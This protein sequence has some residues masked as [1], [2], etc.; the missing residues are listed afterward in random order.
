MRKLFRPRVLV[1]L[2]AAV[3]AIGGVAAAGALLREDP[4]PR[5]EAAP[6]PA[7]SSTTTTTTTTTAPPTT[8]TTLPPDTIIQPA[9]VDLPPVPWEGW[10]PGARAPE[11]QAYEQRLADLR[12][13]PGP[14]DGVF[15]Q[16]TVYAMQGVQKIA[17]FPTS[18]R[19]GPGE[20]PYLETFQ[21]PAPLQVGGEPNR[22]EVDITKQVVTLYE[23]YQPRLITTMSSG[24]GEHY[25]YNSPRDNPT[26]RIC[27][28]AYTPSGR[29]TYYY[30]YDGWHK[31][32]LGQ[33][34]NPYYF[35][36][37]IAVHGY[38]DVPV[39]PA[40]HGC[41]RI[42]MH[43]AEYWNTLVNN[44]DPV[45]V[46]GGQEAVIT[47]REPL[48]GSA[49]PP[50]ADP[51]PIPPP[52]EPAPPPPPEPAPPPPEPVLPTTPSLPTP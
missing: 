38:E 49:S 26:E 51:D 44:D 3:V 5:V 31:S 45:Y 12:F 50:P 11:I 16:S 25:C 7:P 41:V 30:F 20:E 21:F 28:Y 47:S 6:A 27:E 43:I 17:G 23:H 34:Y 36:K 37:G 42:P 24:S 46:F 35:N 15:D 48:G 18:G 22:T 1:S 39:Y 32:P 9:P 4:A 52:G 40:S 13:D 2:L 29:Y 10:G 14:I 19:I 33:L 8:T